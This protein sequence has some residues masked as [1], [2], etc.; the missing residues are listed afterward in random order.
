MCTIMVI[1][2]RQVGPTS[3]SQH[4]MRSETGT[5]SMNT[6]HPKRPLHNPRLSPLNLESARDGP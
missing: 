3:T 2:V 4:N 6:P 1:G 5:T